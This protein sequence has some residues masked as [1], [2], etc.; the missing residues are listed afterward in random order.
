MPQQTPSQTI[1][2]FF[3][4][5]LTP[6]PYGRQ[7]LAGNVLATA[8]AAGRLIRI[9]GRVLDGE[10]AAVSD[11]LI[12]VWQAN[13]HGRYDHPSDARADVPGDP[14]FRGFGRAAS[15]ADGLFWFETVKPGPVRGRGNTLQAPHLN[16]ILFARGMPDH[17][18]TRLY[19]SDE[20]E[21]NAADPVLA[22][23]E[24]A[25]R[26]T[27]IGIREETAGGALYRFDIRLQGDGETVF[28]DA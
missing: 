20:S 10:G 15:D 28:F 6:E 3:A 26:G 8:A 12:E 21:A 13:A 16:L 14:A 17:V 1:G 5:M 18:F 19:F 23:V 9:E 27:L 7:G 25:R 4:Y 22:S 2:P 24:E 11:A